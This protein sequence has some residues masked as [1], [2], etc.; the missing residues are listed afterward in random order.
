M[1]D[2][3]L[4][5]HFFDHIYVLTLKRATERQAQ[6]K[7]NLTG[8]RYQF[9][10]SVDKNDIDV[11][12]LVNNS[13]YDLDA[14]IKN[15]RYHKPMSKGQ[16]A[17]AMGHRMIYEDVIKNNFSKVLILEDDV[18]PVENFSENFSQ[19]MNNLP[20]DWDLL[21][22]DYSKNENTKLAKKLL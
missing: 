3:A 1:T 9:F 7:K 19:V 4:L 10:F 20:F 18:A 12:N 21:Y 5:N 2:F 11:N 6:I 8:L 16:I 15:H 22:F 17:C 13:V 14:G